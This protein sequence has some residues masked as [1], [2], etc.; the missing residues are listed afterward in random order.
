MGPS[1]AAKQWIRLLRATLPPVF[2]ESC[3]QN[4]PPHT[5][6][7]SPCPIGQP[8]NPHTVG[9]HKSV[10]FVS[11]EWFLCA[12]RASKMG[13]SPLVSGDGSFSPHPFLAV[14][15]AGGWKDWTTAE[16]MDLAIRASLK[17]WKFVYLGDVQVK[18]ELPSTFKAFRFQQH[19]WSCG[20]ANLFTKMLME[21][22]TNLPP[23]GSPMADLS[24]ARHPAS[25]PAS[26]A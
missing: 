1:V 19:R 23:C 5:T 21:I 13:S 11:G 12:E 6:S 3:V 4:P 2:I 22:V 16:D 24:N 15:E 18:S 10:Q 20:P 25:L 17:G 26:S 14:N 7:I 9:S 8:H